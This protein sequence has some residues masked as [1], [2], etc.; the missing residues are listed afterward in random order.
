MKLLFLYIIIMACFG[1][2]S[3]KNTKISPTYINEME[4]INIDPK[5]ATTFNFSEAF[6]RIEFVE[7]ETSEE[8]LI[9]E[10]N[11]IIIHNNRI[12]ILDEMSESVYTF[13][14]N[15]HYMYKISAQG[16]GPQ[17]Y[18]SISSEMFIDTINNH[19]ILPANDVMYFDLEDGSFVKREKD[20]LRSENAFVAPGTFAYFL[21]FA[22]WY[23][24]KENLLI[25]DNNK[26]SKYMPI[27]QYMEGVSVIREDMAVFNAYNNE[28]SLYFIEPFNDTIYR[29]LPNTL[30]AV[31][32]VD[33]GNHKVTPSVLSR[34]AENDD[35][36]SIMLNPNSDYCSSI[37]H[38]FE[39]DI[40]YYFSYN[41]KSSGYTYF[42]NKIKN[43]AIHSKAYFDDLAFTWSI[44]DYLFAGESYLVSYIESQEFES[45]KERNN[46]YLEDLKLFAAEN[47]IPKEEMAPL[48]NKFELYKKNYADIINR[49]AQKDENDNPVLIFCHVNT[50]HK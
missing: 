38:F 16:N 11:R 8:C 48:T 25:V 18:S 9:G 44:C 27:P 36:K 43:E 17:E 39:T 20:F 23:E 40:F 2:D 22:N 32:Y 33:F 37:N 6:S 7:L 49:L 13:D 46:S 31:K 12:I 1:C 47:N 15:G 19:L 3:T 24:Y 50:T 14:M 4:V 35:L 21:Y 5:K 29:I 41:Y 30:K 10:I 45:I 28:R 34:Y 26:V 42:Y